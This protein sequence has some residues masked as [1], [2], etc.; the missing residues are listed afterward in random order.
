MDEFEKL[1]RSSLED[2]P[3]YRALVWGKINKL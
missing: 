3:I 1:L 2:Y